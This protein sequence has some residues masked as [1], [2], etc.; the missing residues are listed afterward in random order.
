MSKLKE[1]NEEEHERK[2][3]DLRELESQLRIKEAEQGAEMK[4]LEKAKAEFHLEKSSFDN[5]KRALLAS[6]EDEK[7]RCEE[8]VKKT[9]EEVEKEKQSLVEQK[10]EIQMERA[11]YQVNHRMMIMMIRKIPTVFMIYFL[12]RSIGR[13]T[14]LTRSATMESALTRSKEPYKP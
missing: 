12:L 7:A 8:K 6:V 3:E 1:R 4:Y 2:S 13:S 14:G 11:R 9:L 5:T 10:R